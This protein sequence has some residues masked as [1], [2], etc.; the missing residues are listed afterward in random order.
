MKINL[1]TT[2][3]GTRDL[4]FEE[5]VARRQVEG[6]LAE[7]FR[8]RGFS[9]VMTP[10]LEFYDMFASVAN[11]RDM[12]KLS[13]NK[14]R[15][16]VMRPDSTLPIAR[17]VAAQLQQAPLPIRLYYAQD[18]FHLNHGLYGH[19]D[20]EFQ[21]GVELIGTCGLKAD[22]ETVALAAESLRRAGATDFRLEIGHIGIFRSLTEQ[23][24]C[25]QDC[26]EEIR[27]LIESKSYA[28]LSDLLDR[29]PP[30]AAAEGIR[31]L[32][33][34]FGGAEVLQ[35]AHQLLPGQEAAAA[36]EYLQ[37]L[38]QALCQMGLEKQVQIDLGMV[39]RNE[40]YTGVIFRGYV[41]GSGEMV[42]SGGRYDTLLARFGSAL[43]AIGF[44]I[45]VDA[46]CRVRLQSGG[47]VPP[48][49]AQVLLF[50][51]SGEEAAM[52]RRAEQL[53]QQGICCE[54]SV[55]DTLEQSR[56]YALAKG[57]ASVEVIGEEK[58]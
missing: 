13:D 15:L 7:G 8:L 18:V 58:E 42:V 43:P 39:H 29:L 46:L 44:G 45:S 41:A 23:L 51:P 57:I 19:Y 6:A 36:L 20:Q 56:A 34:L 47:A 48:T 2:P 50:A 9:E 53:T 11:E 24:D 22:I 30:S 35:Q 54:C 26:K 12:Y 21:A 31:R 14:G 3:D 1:R 37:Q 52:Y 5:C 25:D 17:L 40:Y 33:R 16:L 38:Y 4:L 10:G 32:P 49:V 28:A 27:D 55:F